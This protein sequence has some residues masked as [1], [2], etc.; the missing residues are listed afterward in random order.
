MLQLI[1]KKL[2]HLQPIEMFIILFIFGLTLYGFR[3]TFYKLGVKVSSFT[4][5]VLRR[6]LFPYTPTLSLYYDRGFFTLH[7]TMVWLFCRFTVIQPVYLFLVEYIHWEIP[8][9]FVAILLSMMIALGP[10]LLLTA[11]E[12]HNEGISVLHFILCV[13]SRRYIKTILRIYC[14]RRYM[15]RTFFRQFLSFVFQFSLFAGYLA[16]GSSICFVTWLTFIYV[17]MYCDYIIHEVFNPKEFQPFG[18]F[19]PKY[20]ED[21]DDITLTISPEYF[22]YKYRFH[23]W[24]NKLP[25]FFDQDAYVEGFSYPAMDRD[26]FFR[27]TDFFISELDFLEKKKEEFENDPR[28]KMA[29]IS[30]VLKSPQIPLTDEQEATLRRVLKELEIEFKEKY[31]EKRTQKEKPSSTSLKGD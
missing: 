21:E 10:S 6:Y 25:K 28:E 22:F 15:E 1:L 24:R 27:L 31:P 18:V 20:L 8:A 4:E 3:N 2:Q 29:M 17:A 26:D 23:Y 16:T 12:D 13:Y 11:Y 7:W 30:F 14:I 19:D 9:R 5:T